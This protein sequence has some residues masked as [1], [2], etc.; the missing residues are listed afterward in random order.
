M[1]TREEQR[2]FSQL[3]EQITIDR[4]IGYMDAIVTHCEET[5]FEI[6]MAATLL[7]TP[8]KAKINDEAQE[9]NMIKRVAK[10]PI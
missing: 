7:T 2:I 6:E 9:L 3:I 8:I 1:A 5:G 10:L 4:K